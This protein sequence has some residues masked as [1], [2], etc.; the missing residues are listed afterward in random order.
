VSVVLAGRWRG[1]GPAETLL[2]RRTYR[3]GKMSV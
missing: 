3:A 2:R 1:R